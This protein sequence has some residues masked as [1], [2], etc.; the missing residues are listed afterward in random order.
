M[1]IR[2]A[3]AFGHRDGG[4]FQL[5]HGEGDAVDVE[6]EVGALGV[7]ARV[8]R[9]DG[10][11]LGDAEVVALGVFPV[12]QPDIAGLLARVGAHLDAVAQQLVHGAVAVVQALDAVVGGLFQVEYRAACECGVHALR[13][14]K[15][16]QQGGLD[17]AVVGAVGPVAEVGVA[18]G[19]GE[20]SDDVG[21]GGGLGCTN[22]L[23]YFSGASN[24]CNKNCDDRYFILV[25]IFWGGDI[26]SDF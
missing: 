10:D 19:L 2:L 4:A 25:L 7:G 20:E 15:S 16:P 13:Q 8:V 11:F 22:A 3:D 1:L 24:V 26:F 18:E 14:E 9:L 17:V 5:D 21:L 6:H 12:D 23:H